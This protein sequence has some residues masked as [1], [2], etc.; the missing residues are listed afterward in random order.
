MLKEDG[1][2]F[3]C[4]IH[5]T[6]LEHYPIPTVMGLMHCRQLL[7]L[8]PNATLNGALTTSAGVAKQML[9]TILIEDNDKNQNPTARVTEERNWT[10]SWRCLYLRGY[11]LK[12]LDYNVTARGACHPCL[13]TDLL[14]ANNPWMGTSKCRGSF[15]RP[16]E[17]TILPS[18]YHKTFGMKNFAVRKNGAMYCTIYTYLGTSRGVATNYTKKSPYFSKR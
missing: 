9:K 5:C 16:Q 6:H 18:I 13:F 4:W 3:G 14:T 12:V 1:L 2:Y 11:V 17:Y 10:F 8:M 7:T 15:K